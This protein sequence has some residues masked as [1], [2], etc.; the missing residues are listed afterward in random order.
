[1][2]QK[3]YKFLKHYFPKFFQIIFLILNKVDS[4]KLESL[5]KDQKFFGW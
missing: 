1:M 5:I 2:K 4:D 3:I